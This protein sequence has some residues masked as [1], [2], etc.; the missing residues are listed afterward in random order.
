MSKEAKNLF[1]LLAQANY[2][3]FKLLAIVGK[4]DEKKNVIIKTLENIGWTLVDVESELIDLRNEVENKGEITVELITKIKEWFNSKPNKIILINASILYHDVFMKTSPIGAFKYNSRNKNCILFLE[5]EKILGN[6]I[7]Y[8]EFGNPEYF[9]KEIKDI[10]IEKIENID[11]SPPALREPTEELEADVVSGEPISNYFNFELIKDVIDIDN[12][13]KDSNRRKNIVQS[14]IISDSIEEQILDFFDDLDKPT[15]KSRNIIGNYGSGKSHLVAFLVSLVEEKELS[16]YIRNENVRKTLENFHRKFFTVQFELQATQVPLRQWFF[17]KVKKQLQDKYNID[18]PKF[19]LSVDYDDKENIIKIMD[20]IKEKDSEAGLLV[21]I[22][23]VS[24]F[25][26]TKPKEF[27]RQDLQFLRV[28]GQ[29][30]Q[31]EDFMFI[32]S[33]QEDIFTS[34]K[35]KDVADEI[36]RVRERFQN[37]IIHKDDVEK[38]ISERIVPKNDEQKRDLEAKFSPYME[39]IEEVS[40]NID[41]YISLFPLTPF[42]ID[43]FTKMPYFETRGVIQFAMEEIRKSLK[44]AFP[45]FLTFEKIYNLLAN[46]PN[47]RNLPEIRNIVKAMDILTEKIKLLEP[48]YQVDA[49]KISKGLAV[50]SLWEEKGV[51][52][53]ELATKLMIIPNRKILTPE[54]YILSIVKKIR[55]VTDGEYIKVDKDKSSGMIFIRFD[56]KAGVDPEEKISQKAE[57]VSDDEIESELFNQLKKLI[58]LDIQEEIASNIFQD[59]CYW[60]SKKSFRK[61]LVLFQK[62]HSEFN[63]LPQNIDY[64]I[65]LVSPNYNEEVKNFTNNQ[66]NIKI[67]L[68][69]TEAVALL[70]EIVAIKQLMDSGFEKRIMEKKLRERIL[71]FHRGS[72]FIQGFIHRLT[73]LFLNYSECMI[74]D[75][76]VNIKRAVTQIDSSLL[77]IFEDLKTEVFDEHFNKKYPLHP[78]YSEKFSSIN[79]FASLNNYWKELLIGNFNNLSIKTK[80]FLKSLSMLD[81]NDYPILTKSQICQHI[82]EIIKRNSDKVTKIEDIAAELSKSDFGLEKEV[83]FFILAV[84]TLLGKTV[85]KLKGGS[86]DINNISNTLKNLE[87]FETINY[88]QLQKEQSLDIAVNILKTFGLNGEEI[89]YEKTRAKVFKDYKEKIFDLLDKLD[90]IN[91][92]FKTLKSQPVVYIDIEGL[93]Q[94]I[95]AINAI[96]WNEFDIPNYQNFFKLEKFGNNLSNLRK[97][98]DKIKNIYMALNEYD[99]IKIIIEYVNQALEIIDENIIL[100][101]DSEKINSLKQIK[102]DIKKI[103]MDIS[104]YIDAKNRLSIN[105]KFTMFQKIYIHNIYYPVHEKFVGNKVNWQVLD[106]IISSDTFKAISQI[107][108]ISKQINDTKFK[109]L[110]IKID[111]L[112][113]VRC[114]NKMLLENLKLNPRCQKCFFPKNENYSKK[115]SEIINM[116]NKFENLL[117]EYQKTLISSIREYRD[118]IQFLDTEKEKNF[119]RKILE[120]NKFPYPILTNDD[121]NTI[122]K[123]FKEIELISMN[124]EE[125]INK[126]FPDNEIVSINQIKEN[127]QKCLHDII[128]SRD[129]NIV[130]IKLEN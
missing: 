33:M 1:S 12:D 73:Q 20:I 31:D 95:I 59:E 42:L 65:V 51:I 70:K 53:K 75:E 120:N 92:A 72:V 60:K 113:S 118:N 47:R 25:L 11:D 116:E 85:L 103:C 35:F 15:H 17:D 125:I 89:L 71:G 98:I 82:L 117:E 38:V 80:N 8:S 14:F 79:I 119:I 44:M 77:G 69:S 41:S 87:S 13:L 56:T 52:P 88:I 36:A 39:K 127:F 55:D 74:N 102:E 50:L 105:G 101:I 100:Q 122:N 83:V 78:V 91:N 128:G 37:I 130:R 28:V 54:D 90:K 29:L 68:K 93:E 19:D 21:V 112:K 40:K 66:L 18:I 23:E 67:H 99:K 5:E 106:D 30:S 6:K 109:H 16:K 115:L 110:R 121:I 96:N 45:Y 32:C 62:K 24:D 126:I 43:L 26:L 108:K 97:L 129:E 22:D 61:G 76:P 49:L 4:D 10:V 111:E 7:Y 58:E 9:E 63:K 46:D 114:T 64:I 84:M 104:K 3:R 94:E 48:E 27:L 57:A 124:K 123:L 34:P 2:M 107:V 86:I 81:E